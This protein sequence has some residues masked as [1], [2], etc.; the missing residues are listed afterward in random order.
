M[1]EHVTQRGD[2]SP[3]IAAVITSVV[4]G[5]SSLDGGAAQSSGGESQLVLG[6]QRRQTSEGPCA[7]SGVSDIPTSGG[8]R[9]RERA[10]ARERV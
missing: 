10:R 8:E 3:G 1:R 2:K 5:Y 4:L 6:F 7:V 9:E